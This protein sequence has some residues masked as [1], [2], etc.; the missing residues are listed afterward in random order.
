M[1]E[2][3]N[4]GTMIPNSTNMSNNGILEKFC[5]DNNAANCDV[6]GGLYQWHEM[7]QYAGGGNPGICPAN[8][9]IPGEG[10]WAA[11]TNDLGG[12]VVAGGKMKTTGTI[13]AGTGLWHTPNTATNS[14]GFS[15]LPGGWYNS[16]AGTF[17]Y[18]GYNTYFWATL[19]WWGLAAYWRSLH[20]DS[21]FINTSF[22][23]YGY[24]LSVRCIK[25]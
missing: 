16:D 3:L 15:G 9:H 21:E 20:Y 8:W 23:S 18:Q 19:E 4:I 24:G 11:I 6:Y 12:N 10:E 25:N 17:A 2:N 5:Y 13:E 14:S 1:A 22:S 7:M